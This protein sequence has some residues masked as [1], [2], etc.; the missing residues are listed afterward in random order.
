MEGIRP[1]VELIHNL[2]VEY[3]EVERNIEFL[4]EIT[5]SEENVLDNIKKKHSNFYNTLWFWIQ[6]EKI[7]NVSATFS[8]LF[9]MLFSSRD[10]MAYLDLLI[11]KNSEFVHWL[12]YCDLEL[13]N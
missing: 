6:V 3:S 2:E 10:Y 4:H 9:Y 5:I 12:E 1:K 8:G 7:F 13:S 11:F